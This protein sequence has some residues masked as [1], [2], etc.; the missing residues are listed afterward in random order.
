M[1]LK[2]I[3]KF[4]NEKVDTSSFHLEDYVSTENLLPNKG[5]VTV[6]SKIPQ[7]KATLFKK[8]DILISNI[9][10]YFKKIYLA[11]KQGCCSNDVLCIR[12]NSNIPS[13]YLYYLLSQDSFFDYVMTGAKGTKMPRGDKGHIMNWAVYQSTLSQQQNIAEI[14]APLD[15][16]I[17]VNSRICANLEAQAEALFKSWFVDFTPFKDQPFVDSELGPI[18][19]GWKVG[20]LGDIANII[21]GQSPAG[22]SYN[23]RGNGV[24]FYQGRT[25]FGFR[26]PNVRLYTT[27]P[28]RYAEPMSILLSVRAPVGDINVAIEKCCIGR[29]LASI[30]SKRGLHSFLLYLV[31]SLKNRLEVFN[32]EGTVFGSINKNTLMQFKIIIPPIEMQEKFNEIIQ[33]HDCM[34]LELHKEIINLSTQRDTLLP[35]LMSGE[36]KL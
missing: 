21:M 10:P 19:Q 12:P 4:V 6:A 18:P 27:M 25:E 29:G 30:S 26:F 22:S 9:R 1:K 24:I 16:K 17:A 7:G 11:K 33:R 32:G 35:K 8:G 31:K 28:K 23:E 20:T 15:D 5:G 34:V 2:D 14:L 36:I 13:S 3:C